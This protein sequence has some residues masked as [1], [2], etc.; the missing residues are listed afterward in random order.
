MPK[1]SA[2][3]ALLALLAVA[4]TLAFDAVLTT[5]QKLAEVRLVA[6]R[7]DDTAR[8]CTLAR[9]D[10]QRRTEAL[11][12]WGEPVEP[13]RR[14]GL[15]LADGSLLLADRGW[16]PRGLVQ[17]KRDTVEV[18]RGKGW[19]A[20]PRATVRWV[21]TDLSVIDDSRDEAPDDESDTLLL[22]SGDRISGSLLLMTGEGAS[23]EVAGETIQ[24]P[25][26]NIAAVRLA[27]RRHAP[28]ARCLVG[29]R[30]GSHLRAASLVIE[31]ETATVVT[32]DGVRLESAAEA[33]VLVQPLGGPVVYLSDLEPVD[34]QHT[35][36]LDLVWPYARDSGLR[37]GPLV[38]GGRRAAKG[39]ALHSA[40]RL[41]YRLDGAAD[42][43]R[44]DAAVADPTVDS[45]AEGSVVFRVYLVKDG[46]FVPAYDS[47]VV[48]AGE[49]ARRVDVD[50]TGA[51]AIAL[52][53]DYADRGDAGDDALW[54]DAQLIKTE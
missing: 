2:A 26:E 32:P 12:R 47:G 40:A 38:G 31:D 8:V 15:V 24:T 28:P 48:R 11:V 10:E 36:Y 35:P 46:V 6:C 49:P 9:G 13:L 43:F 27:G 4:P 19:V 50:L 52:V 42:R 45:S 22:T 7:F 14:P 18:R 3:V 16:S 54:L 17:V 5:G 44:C 33:V 39:L 23:V 21:G 41:V 34:Y 20:A 37:N 1:S 30:D 53:V 29:F 25:L 51:A